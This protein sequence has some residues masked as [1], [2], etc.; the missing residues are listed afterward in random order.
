MNIPNWLDKLLDVGDDEQMP[1]KG[2]KDN[3]PDP[4]TH[5]DQIP[6]KTTGKKKKKSAKGILKNMASVKVIVGG[7][8]V[9]II[10]ISFL[11]FPSNGNNKTN[12]PENKIRE[13]TLDS[14]VYV[15]DIKFSIDDYF[16]SDDF[17]DD[18]KSK[19]T[20][21]AGN[22]FLCIKISAQNTGTVDRSLYYQQQGASKTPAVTYSL[23]FSDG[24]T[25]STTGQDSNKK[26]LE[27]YTGKIIPLQTVSRYVC[28]EVPAL[29]ADSAA[30]LALRIHTRNS[31]VIWYLRGT[32]KAQETT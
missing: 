3:A 5:T 29:V 30:P 32:P 21:A 9:L 24:Y 2:N 1:T 25:Y 28:F 17:L 6:K 4:V 11:T 15:G 8:V 7:I 19:I 18:P 31:T 23:I 13:Y 14:D 20:H 26:L 27:N 16:F 10:V 22:V 12:E